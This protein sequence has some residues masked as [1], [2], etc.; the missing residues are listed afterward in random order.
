MRR[1]EKEKVS[2]VE[3]LAKIER[4]K[5][6]GDRQK[7][8]E[9]GTVE[10]ETKKRIEELVARRVEEEFELRA[11][12]MRE[13]VLRKVEIALKIMKEQMMKTFKGKSAKS[14]AWSHVDHNHTPQI[15]HRCH[16]CEFTSKSN[17]GVSRH[18]TKTHKKDQP[19]KEEELKEEFVYEDDDMIVLD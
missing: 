10:M 9:A 15:E 17:D 2:E 18:I 3:R 6:A 5:T 13:K 19:K 1:K 14:N 7:E 12:Q 4:R 16:M 8:I 11:E